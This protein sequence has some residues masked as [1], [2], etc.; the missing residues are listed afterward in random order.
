MVVFQWQRVLE[1]EHFRS[2]RALAVALIPGVQCGLP[3]AEVLVTIG[4]MK[5]G[6][7]EQGGCDKVGSCGCAV[8]QNGHAVWHCLPEVPQA[9]RR[10]DASLA[11]CDLGLFYF[12]GARN[13][14]FYN[15]LHV[16]SVDVQKGCTFTEVACA[17]VVPAPRSN[18]A[19][20]S[21]GG[22]LWLFGGCDLARHKMYSD[23][24]RFDGSWA[25]IVTSAPPP[26]RSGH[27]AAWVK[28]TFFVIGGWDGIGMLGDIW[29]LEEGVWSQVEG[30]ISPRACFG[31]GALGT[32]LLIFGGLDDK[33][34]NDGLCTGSCV[35][36][37]PLSLL[38]SLDGTVTV[39]IEV[40]QLPPKRAFLG[41][42]V[43]AGTSLLIGFGADGPASDGTHYGD[44]YLCRPITWSVPT[45]ALFPFAARKRVF[46]WLLIRHRLQL[47]P[48][49]LW[50]LPLQWMDATDWDRGAAR[51]AAAE[52]CEERPMELFPATED[53][54]HQDDSGHFCHA[55][56]L[57]LWSYLRPC[58]STI[59]HAATCATGHASWHA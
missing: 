56:A 36:L 58:I 55:S 3:G 21:Q 4:G 57:L 40:G 5:G 51:G 18:T 44:V 16:V 38:D 9:M 20:I 8:L 26:A 10:H 50:I 32:N 49:H 31:L 46:F 41:S 52:T 48:S 35:Q 6:R 17:N 34:R 37:S 2:R 45:H 11:L 12:G 25:Q 24:W 47:L 15:D 1:D 43:C 28:N 29:S 22:T 23:L 42:S 27:Q 59:T 33:Y 39:T 54:Q 53:E 30:R 7:G 13:R 19:F 14:M